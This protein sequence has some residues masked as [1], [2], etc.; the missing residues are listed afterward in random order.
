MRILTIF[1][2]DTYLIILIINLMFLNIKSFLY[3]SNLWLSTFLSYCK[4]KI[5]KYFLIAFGCNMK[6]FFCLC[7]KWWAVQWNLI[8]FKV[9]DVT[10]FLKRETEWGNI[11]FAKKFVFE[12]QKIWKIAFEFC[13][14]RE[15]MYKILLCNKL[16]V[17][18]FC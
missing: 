2:C 4:L 15:C 13:E 9:N 5:I 3:M 16:F 17:C 10:F 18:I 7:A 1:G 11:S 14:E 6:T 8:S 12:I